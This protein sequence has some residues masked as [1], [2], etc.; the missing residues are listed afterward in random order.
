MVITYSFFQMIYL[1]GIGL[2]LLFYFLNILTLIR[3]GFWNKTAL[4]VS[5]LTG[6]LFLIIIGA[7]LGLLKDIDW[8]QTL[9]LNFE[10]L[11]PSI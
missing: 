9:K 2:I 3:Y 4:G 1:G 7:T 11:I 5:L 6:F 10:F 8:S